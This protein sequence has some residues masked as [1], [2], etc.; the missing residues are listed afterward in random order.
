MG[1]TKELSKDVRDKIVDL[2]KAGMGYK[3]IDKQLGEKETTVG[4][5]IRKW[6]KHE[7]TINRPRSDHSHQENH[8]REFID[9]VLLTNKPY[10][11]T[12]RRRGQVT[13]RGQGGVRREVTHVAAS[14]E[15]SA[16]SFRFSKPCARSGVFTN[17]AR[18]EGDKMALVAPLASEGRAEPTTG[19]DGGT[20]KKENP[21]VRAA[22]C[23]SCS[24]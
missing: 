21:A 1:K 5:I 16:V 14:R 24:L 19:P 18:E 13:D 23:E 10:S 11:I 2:H 7:M 20:K 15:R 4:A 3:T 22:R 9:L 12:W 6:K 8:W 17:Y